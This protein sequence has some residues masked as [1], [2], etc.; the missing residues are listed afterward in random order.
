MNKVRIKLVTVGHLPLRLNISKA[1]QWKSDIFEVIGEAENYSIRSDSD[2]DGWEFTDANLSEQLPTQFD[3]NFLI[4]IANVPIEHNWYS[5][6]LGGNKIV[7]TFHQIKEYLLDENIPL[8]NA[9]IR[10]LYVYTLLYKKSGNR[11]PNYDEVTRYTHDETRGCIFDMNGIKSDLV[12]SCV[13]PIVCDECQERLRTERVSSEIIKTT[14]KE[15]RRIKKELYY[16]A[17]DFIKHHPVW[18][19]I[20]SS[21]FAVVLGI[22]GSLVAS[23][24][25]DGIKS[26][27]N[28]S[29]EP[30]TVAP[31]KL[32]P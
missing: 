13:R 27:P 29:M 18:A 10:V 8:E 23:Y 14:Q 7:F 31:T 19:L 25:Y 21:A 5:R 24:I 28:T 15:I 17:I 9:I 3:G 16:R 6:R 2:G 26:Q 12:E 1:V 11:I 22:A 30:K 32:S 20:F 4:A